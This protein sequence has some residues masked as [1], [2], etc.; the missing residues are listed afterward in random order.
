MHLLSTLLLLFS[1]A[2]IVR[3]QRFIVAVQLHAV[4][5]RR[6]TYDRMLL[7]DSK[8]AFRHCQRIVLKS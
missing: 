8:V 7:G 2:I 5:I 3:Y 6:L 1:G 4:R